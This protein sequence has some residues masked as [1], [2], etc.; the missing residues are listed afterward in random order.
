MGLNKKLIDNAL[1]NEY[2]NLRS[3]A[4]AI[5]AIKADSEMHPVSPEQFLYNI[6]KF[7]IRLDKAN[8]KAAK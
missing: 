3:K 6:K 4:K 2:T 5:A 8:E 7:K 1:N